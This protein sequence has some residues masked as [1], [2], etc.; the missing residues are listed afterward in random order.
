MRKRGRP[1][2]AKTKAAIQFRR[3][4]GFWPT[5]TTRREQL[6]T[7]IRATGVLPVH[8]RSLAADLVTACKERYS[9]PISLKDAGATAFEVL[10]SPG[11][12]ILEEIVLKLTM[13]KVYAPNPHDRPWI[14]K[15]RGAC[16]PHSDFNCPGVFTLVVC[17]ETDQPYRMAIS[18]RKELFEGEKLDF[19]QYYE[20]ELKRFSY[21]I[22]PSCMIHR[23]IAPESN[24]RTILN[25]LVK[26]VEK[27]FKVVR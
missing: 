19:D 7:I 3:R 26:I 5:R 1:R 10:G 18:R 22:F 16:N 12:S 13:M 6:E 21:V 20:V 11:E 2:K 25:V 9:C 27:N 14:L 23:C 15:T 8:L 24:S 4:N 17:L